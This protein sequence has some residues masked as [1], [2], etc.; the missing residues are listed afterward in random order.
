MHPTTNFTLAQHLLAWF[1]NHGRKTLPWQQLRSPYRVWVSE[2]MLQQTQVTTCIAYF[3][4]FTLHFPDVQ[5]LAQAP[6]DAVL[7]L[8]SGLGYYARARNLHRAAGIIVHDFGGEFPLSSEI[9][10][11]LPGIG[12]STA[13]A[14][15]ALSMNQ[16]QPI[17]DGNVKRVLTR[18]HAIEGWPGNR[19]VE[20][21]LWQ[22]AESHTPETEV[23]AYTQAIMDLGATLCTRSN[24]ACPRCP[25][26]LNCQAFQNARPTDFPTKKPKKTLP[27]RHTFMLLLRN[28]EAEVLLLKRPPTG[29]WGGLWGLPECI[30]KQTALAFAARYGEVK[31]VSELAS[32]RHT[33]SHFHLDITPICLELTH[34]P[35]CVMEP[36]LSLW[37]NSSSPAKVGLAAPVKT[38]LSRFMPHDSHGSVR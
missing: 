13:G 24:P 17:L 16:R 32:L 20:A 35:N 36:G 33:F 27:T 4:R 28:Q 8:W 30:D 14:I 3:E 25:L 37:Y 11:Q 21:T 29:I 9:L 2:I 10:Q 15:L 1:E 31:T 26:Q 34:Q 23:A 22:L 18:F 6:L 19:E 5:S 38:L 7:H 12:R